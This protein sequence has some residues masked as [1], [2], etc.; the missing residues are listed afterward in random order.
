[1]S[2][3]AAYGIEAAVAAALFTVA[4]ILSAP[5]RRRAAAL[6]GAGVRGAAE[7]AGMAGVAG[8]VARPAL[9]LL[10]TPA[11]ALLAGTDGLLQGWLEGHSA[12]L[13]AWYAFWAL[14]AAIGLAEAIARMCYVVRDRPFPVPRLIRNILN[15]VLVVAAAFGVLKGVLGI[16]ISPLLASTALLTA[17]VGFAL[18]GVLGNLLA[19]MSIHIVRSTVPGDW[20]AIGDIEGEVIETNWRETRLRTVA[21]HIMVIPNSKVADSVIHNMSHPTPLR[22]HRIPVGASY[23]DAPA[24]VIAALVAAARSVPEVLA[25]P[26]P[27]AYLTEFKDFGINYDLRFW[28]RRY[29]DRTPV[30]GDVQRMIWYE[31]KRRAIEIPFPM[32]DKLLNDFM[33]VV[34]TQRQKPP[35]E[36]ELDRRA[37]DFARS[38]FCAK[39]LAGPD[40]RP[41]LGA[42]EVREAA[43]LMRHVQYTRGEAIFRQGDP[44][45][46][47]FVLVG[48]TLTGRIEFPDAAQPHTFELGSGALAGEMSLVTGLPRTATLTA[49]T[50]VELLEISSPAFQRLLSLRDDI[51][52]RLSELVAQRAAANAAS[53]EKLKLMAPADLA[54]TLQQHTILSRLLRLLGR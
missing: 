27:S 30:Q 42:V 41:L 14:A 17:V 47:A 50:E 48:G 7:A 8:F 24:A 39:L 51:P 21:G 45:D 40:G 5:L 29:Q 4:H 32:S 9:V 1:M 2:I 53:Y 15:T 37:A 35:D 16:D 26:P 38:D 33:E 25:D 44:G 3:Y 36:R 12:H 52:Q 18:Q 28:T 11:A 22:R 46:A 43:R 13:R 54:G 34:Y 6:A 19:G 10:L 49:A 31:F 20:V 23:S